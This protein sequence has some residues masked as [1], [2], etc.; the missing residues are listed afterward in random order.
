MK[1]SEAKYKNKKN[2]FIQFIIKLVTNNLD[3]IKEAEIKSLS[4]KIYVLYEGAV[5]ES[6]LHQADWPIKEAKDLCAML[7]K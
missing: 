6:N 4:R 7:L 2:K 1:K 3:N 5:V